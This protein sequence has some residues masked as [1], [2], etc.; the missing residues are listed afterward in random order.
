VLQVRKVIG[1]FAVPKKCRICQ[2]R[3]RGGKSCPVLA[4]LCCL[5]VPG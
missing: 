1:P 5:E 2:R 4:C 3:G